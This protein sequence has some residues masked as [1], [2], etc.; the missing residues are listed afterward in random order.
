MKKLDAYKIDLKAIQGE[1]LTRSL[2]AD[3]DFFAE[4]QGDEIQRGNV[5]LDM[6]VRQVAGAYKVR[7]QFQGEVQV[8][9]DR[10]LDPMMQPVEGDV[11]LSVKLGEEFEDDGDLI[12]VPED[13][14]ILDIAWQ[15]YEQIALQIPLSHV[16]EE[17]ECNAEMEKALSQHQ[18][19]EAGESDEDE[20]A[21]AQPTDPRWDALK[22]LISTNN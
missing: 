21:E 5:T 13:E 11:E 1:V 14:G 17:G 9:C 15:V 12:I 3:N 6:Q 22:K 20:T 7:L 16:H 10:C 18:P 2:V 4:V 19:H 8:L